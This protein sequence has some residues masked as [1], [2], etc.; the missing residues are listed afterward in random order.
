MPAVQFVGFATQCRGEQLVPQANAEDGHAGGHDALDGGD[1]V[2]G[3][4][5]GVAGAV[6]EEDA[7]RL[8]AQDVLGGGGGGDDDD[9]AAGGGE[10]AQ[11]VALGAV[12]DRDDGFDGFGGGETVFPAPGAAGPFVG[13]QA[14]DFCGEVQA[15][16]AA[17]GGG[18]GGEGGDVELA[19]SGV[20]EHG[21]GGAEVADAQGDGARV[22]ARDAGDVHAFQPGVEIGRGA[23]VGGGGSVLLDHQATG[24][25]L[26]GFA[27]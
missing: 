14:G 1:G 16:E 3:G 10:R 4:G 2:G 26:G 25:D 17:P 23:V 13:L 6:G 15:V 21:G 24:E 11:D 9:A 27:R 22:N 20:G 19:V 7:V 5:G 12:V 18:G 8:V